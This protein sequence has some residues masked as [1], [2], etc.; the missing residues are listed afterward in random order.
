MAH[1]KMRS[2][3]QKKRTSERAKRPIVMG[4]LAL[5]FPTM[6]NMRK[7]FKPALPSRYVLNLWNIIV[8]KIEDRMMA[9]ELMFTCRVSYI[10]TCGGDTQ[11]W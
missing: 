9:E 3:W 1:V 7:I 11:M 8:C 6:R 10:R 5:S 4:R 2:S